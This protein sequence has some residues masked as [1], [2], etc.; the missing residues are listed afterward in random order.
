MQGC[1]AL[2]SALPRGLW[3]LAASHACTAYFSTLTA[4][5]NAEPC[6]TLCDTPCTGLSVLCVLLPVHCLTVC[7]YS[8]Y[9]VA[10]ISLPLRPV[11]PFQVPALSPVRSAA[12]RL[13]FPRPCQ[14]T[15]TLMVSS[16]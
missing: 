10:C 9:S 14:S 4:A 8:L 15:P 12:A 16:T 1:G 5:A 6:T 11:L 7:Y 2:A 13:S 3:T